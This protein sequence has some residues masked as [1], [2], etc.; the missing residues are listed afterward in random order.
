MRVIPNAAIDLKLTFVVNEIEA[1]ALAALVDYSVDD[2]INACTTHMGKL[3]TETHDA[4]LR[5]FWKCIE[6]S[7]RPALERLAD[8][9]KV[10]LGSHKAVEVAGTP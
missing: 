9:K 10:F 4:G 8:S 3:S 6:D 1:R 2:F 7:V 5:E